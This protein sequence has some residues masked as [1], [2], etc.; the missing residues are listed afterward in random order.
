MRNESCAYNF[1][2]IMT[3]RIFHKLFS[4]TLSFRSLFPTYH[5]LPVQGTGRSIHIA[6][7]QS[8][9]ESI[10]EVIEIFQKSFLHQ[11]GQQQLIKN[12]NDY[13]TTEI[14]HL[15][16]TQT[17]CLPEFLP[18]ALPPYFLPSSLS[19]SSFFSSLLFTL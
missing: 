10:E 5:S 1:T 19:F 16:Y 4:N 7:C 15:I 9:E 17:A 14:I 6:I 11:D 3:G 8:T 12:G 2:S 13:E 18:S